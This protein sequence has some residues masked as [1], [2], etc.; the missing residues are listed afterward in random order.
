MMNLVTQ[1]ILKENIVLSHFLGIHLLE[2]KKRHVF[3]L[4]ISLFL[5]TWISYL[6]K[7]AIDIELIHLCF[8]FLIFFI[9]YLLELKFF[10]HEKKDAILMSSMNFVISFFTIQTIVE[11]K[12]CLAYSIGTTLGLLLL[13]LLFSCFH[14][15]WKRSLIP[16]RF[17]GIPLILVT[18]SV[19][20][21]LIER[22]G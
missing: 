4:A 20:A 16:N 13:I 2:E 21:L 18:L 5:V 12:T 7:I 11:L 22:Y 8:P 6:F 10:H 3:F 15:K 9:L 14:T 17:K 1:Y 19:I